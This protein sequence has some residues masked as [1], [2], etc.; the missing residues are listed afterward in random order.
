M[1]CVYFC[2]WSSVEITRTNFPFICV[3]ITFTE[4]SIW[5]FAAKIS[6]HP[7]NLQLFRA[8]I[9]GLSAIILGSADGSRFGYIF[10]GNQESSLVNFVFLRQTPVPP[11]A[12]KDDDSWFQWCTWFCFALFCFGYTK[13]CCKFRFIYPYSSGSFEFAKLS[14]VTDIDKIIGF[15]TTT[16]HKARSKYTF[17]VKFFIERE[18]KRA[19]RFT[20]VQ[21]FASDIHS[22]Y[23]QRRRCSNW[24][25]TVPV[26][27]AF[28]GVKSNNQIPDSKLH[29]PMNFAI[30]DGCIHH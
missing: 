6:S 18:I 19:T 21:Q 26:R 14:L 4:W 15:L 24:N 12:P 25:L 8:D 30:W 27:L 9:S 23:P 16:R 5:R 2:A 10:T 28:P 1:A 13:M 22:P 20:L 17:L 3:A 7:S 29:G 11:V